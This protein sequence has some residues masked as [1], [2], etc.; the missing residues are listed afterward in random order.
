MYAYFVILGLVVLV[1]E[2]LYASCEGEPSAVPTNV[3]A[4]SSPEPAVSTASQVPPKSSK[5]VRQCPVLL[6]L[7]GLF[8]Q[9]IDGFFSLGSSESSL[10]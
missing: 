9:L 1:L 2:E 7:E 8:C 5:K 4:V 3:I 10:Y 6:G